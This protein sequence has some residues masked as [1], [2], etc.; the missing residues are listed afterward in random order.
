MKLGAHREGLKPALQAADAVWA[1]QPEGL[2]WS[3]AESLEGLPELVV[4]GNVEAL[5]ASVAAAAQSGDEIVIM[6]NGGFGGFHT[7]LCK[8]LA[9]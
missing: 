6:S 5:V 9:N 1:L 4:E 2:E 3:V 8:A 7:Q